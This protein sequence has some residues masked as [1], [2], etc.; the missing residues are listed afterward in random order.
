MLSGKLIRLIESH[1][2]QISNSI[3]QQVRHDPRLTHVRSLPEP[4]LRALREDLLR[5]LSHWLISSREEEIQ[6]R[7]EALGRRRF[8]EGIPL[9]E[10]VYG[11]LIVKKRMIEFVRNQGLGATVVEVYAEEELEHRVDCFFDDLI[12]Y[13]VRGYESALRQAA[14]LTAGV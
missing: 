6:P 3:L 2:E 10:A 7:F 11:L 12:Y 9:H 14:R 13:L 5:N 4:E 8:E 1:W